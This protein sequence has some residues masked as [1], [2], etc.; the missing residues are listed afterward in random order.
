MADRAKKISELTAHSNPP[1]NNVLAIVHQP[2]LA[3]AETRKITLTN[4]FANV[5]ALTSNTV[6]VKTVLTANSFNVGN[7]AAANAFPV[8]IGSFIGNANG[9]IQIAFQNQ[10]AGN[11][12]STDIALYSDSGNSEVNFIDIG[13]V[14]STYNQGSLFHAHDAYV[15]STGQRMLVGS[16]SNSVS[17]FAGGYD[18]TNVYAELYANGVF[19]INTLTANTLHVTLGNAPANSTATGIVGQIRTDS[20]Y[21]YVCT[22]NNT[23]KRAALTTWP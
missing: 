4:L 18:D 21:I 13:I 23:W 1:A 8:S 15:Y 20:D 6:T 19:A 12:S 16:V 10:N 22:A 11:N 17:F 9:F 2:G 3:N 7:T 5:A 14:S